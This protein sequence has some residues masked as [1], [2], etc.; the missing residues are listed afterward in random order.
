[1]LT[2][3]NNPE[4]VDDLDPGESYLDADFGFTPAS[5]IGDY[6]WQ[7][8][9]GDGEQDSG[10]PGIAGVTV[11]LCTSSPCTSGNA[12]ATDVTD[13]NGLYEFS[14]LAART[15]SDVYVVAV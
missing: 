7:D 10:E 12:I 1:M 8:N 3:N 6:I 14:G 2:T 13:A 5:I 4:A 11:Y 15:G 9:D